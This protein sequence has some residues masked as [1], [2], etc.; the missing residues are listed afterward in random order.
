MDK[1]D[2]QEQDFMEFLMRLPWS[3]GIICNLFARRMIYSRKENALPSQGEWI[4]FARRIFSFR[5]ENEYFRATSREN[6]L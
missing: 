2:F 5:K 4:I 3:R 6:A 1:Q